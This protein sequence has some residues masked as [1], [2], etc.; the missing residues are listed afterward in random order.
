[1]IE[2]D[3][4]RLARTFPREESKKADSAFEIRNEL[5]DLLI[6]RH[7]ASIGDRYRI[8]Q[9]ISALR[10]LLKRMSS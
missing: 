3:A 6:M 9:Q 7:G 2:F 5:Q 8:D 1:M 4:Y 10:N